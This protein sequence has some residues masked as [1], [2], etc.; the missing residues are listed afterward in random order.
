MNGLSRYKL[1]DNRFFNGTIIGTGI[2]G[3]AEVEMIIFFLG[4]EVQGSKLY[5]IFLM[6]EKKYCIFSGFP[7]K[8]PIKFPRKF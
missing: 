4:T 6:P 3:K 2:S 5:R 8:I 1:N 7:R